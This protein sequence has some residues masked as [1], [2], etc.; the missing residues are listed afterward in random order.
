MDLEIGTDEA[1]MI[2][3]RRAPTLKRKEKTDH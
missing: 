1:K 3:N 2:Q